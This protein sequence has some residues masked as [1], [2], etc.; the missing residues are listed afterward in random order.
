[1]AEV[2]GA[3]LQ[4]ELGQDVAEARRLPLEAD[5]A[6]TVDI[7]RR[8]GLEAVDHVG[9]IALARAAS[10]TVAVR[11]PGVV[12][13]DRRDARG[14]QRIDQVRGVAGEVVAEVLAHAE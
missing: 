12:E 7:E 13:L 6:A 14:E 9:E 1:V 2:A 10:R 3:E 5:R 11:V 4:G 8:L